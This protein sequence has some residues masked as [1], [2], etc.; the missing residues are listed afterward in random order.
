MSYIK[1]ESQREIPAS[2]LVKYP[3]FSYHCIHP[4][5]SY[6]TGG[7]Q[8]SFHATIYN[9]ML[10]T[11]TMSTEPKLTQHTYQMTYGVQSYAV[12]GQ[13]DS[14]HHYSWHQTTVVAC[15]CRCHSGPDSLHDPQCAGDNADE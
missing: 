10:F 15:Q 13:T 14:C 2:D 7:S 1:F 5:G 11:K 3:A 6:L 8:T 12:A 9:I 4:A